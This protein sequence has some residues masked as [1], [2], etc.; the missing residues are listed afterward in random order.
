V[1]FN[2]SVFFIFFTIFYAAYISLLN[3][4]LERK[5]LTLAGSFIF[6]AWW[7]YRF[8]L[9]IAASI[10]FNYYIASASRSERAKQ[11][12]KI[13]LTVAIILNLS[14]LGVFKYFNFFIESFA[15][16]L[17]LFFG[18]ISTGALN[19]ILPVGIS[20][21][22]FQAMSY[23]IDSY[24]GEIAKEPTLLEFSVYISLFPQLVAGP[25][26][27]AS[28]LLPQIQSNN[29]KITR[30]DIISGFNMIVWGLFLKVALA[31]NA[32]PIADRYFSNIGNASFL[33]A[34]LGVFAFAMQIY[35]D[36]AGYSLMAIGL[37]RWLGFDFGINFRRPYF[38]TS[39]SDFWR[40]WHISLSS[41]LRDY[42]Y[43]ALGGN[44]QG[45]IKTYVNLFLTML[46]GGLWH[47]ASWNFVIWGALH[48]A[49]LVIERYFN[50]P[51]KIDS[52]NGPIL[53][54]LN[55][56]LYCIFVFLFVCIAW[57]FF[58]AD[59]LQNSLSTINQMFSISDILPI[60]SSHPIQELILF[61][62]CFVVVLAKDSI[63]EIYSTKVFSGYIMYQT[64][65]IMLAL[66]ILIVI[67]HF[68][69]A[70]FIYFQF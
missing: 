25:I 47:G 62:I 22:T 37:G 42:L 29:V 3:R 38:A 2:S 7:D 56:A 15:N 30:E 66:F 49:Y 63:S 5:L 6:Y 23:V 21:F 57:V 26:V 51:N 68:N 20:F 64:I 31:E 45:N 16:L 65:F 40:R 13:L 24:R 48:G 50:I 55:T 11:K 59:T 10:A 43:I 14:L 70:A 36:F 61:A 17:S 53:R 58:R 18:E 19:I 54:K 4:H 69:G 33:D 28:S 44:R 67:G 34:W 12:K 8:L 39:F 41:W 35:G 32:A 27:R 1:I 60:T 9:L 52:I 46:L